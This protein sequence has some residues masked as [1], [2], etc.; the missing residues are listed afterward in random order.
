MVDAGIAAGGMAGVVVAGCGAADAEPTPEVTTN[1]VVPALS[2]HG[3]RSPQNAALALSRSAARAAE[4][5]L[6]SA[7]TSLTLVVAACPEASS[8]V[9]G[10]ERY[11]MSASTT[12]GKRVC[13]S[14]SI[15]QA[16][17]GPRHGP[18]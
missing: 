10:H 5:S 8:V 6:A 17:C 4:A 3:H 2:T 12:T 15:P 11:D 9:L 14:S 18:M 1:E 16:D 7:R 13:R